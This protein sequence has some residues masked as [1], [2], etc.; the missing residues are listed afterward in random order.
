MKIIFELYLNDVHR[1]LCIAASQDD[2]LLKLSLT[3]PQIK[4]LCQRTIRDHGFYRDSWSDNLSDF[5]EILI[6]GW[7]GVLARR[8]TW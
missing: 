2:E 8:Y 7:A 4:D 1:L 5:E 6:S 3:K